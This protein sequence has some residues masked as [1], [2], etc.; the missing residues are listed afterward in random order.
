SF[1]G[2]GHLGGGGGRLRHALDHVEIDHGRV[3]GVDAHERRVR[4]VVH[5]EQ[6]GASLERTDLKHFD[7]ACAQWCQDL[8]PQWD[9]AACPVECEI[10]AVIPAVD[11]HSA[12]G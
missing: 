10:L 2:R 9:V 3:P 5:E 12:Y 1:D 4:Q 8:Q 6:G 11:F 7:A